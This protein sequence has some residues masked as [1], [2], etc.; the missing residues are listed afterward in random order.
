MTP[1]QIA[2]RIRGT[3]PDA[4]VEAAGADCSF[5]VLV[6]SQHLEG[7]ST[8]TRQRSLLALFSP[9]LGSGELHALSIRARTPA[10]LQAEKKASFVGLGTLP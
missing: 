7:Q 10:E 1:E 9:E 6:V 3:L 2:T 5:E 8:L 4:Q